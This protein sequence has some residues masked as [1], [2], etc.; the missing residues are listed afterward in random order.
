[1]KIVLA[2]SYLNFLITND[3]ILMPKYYKKGR[4]IHFKG[5]WGERGE[6]G[7]RGERGE[8]GGERGEGREGREKGKSSVI[9]I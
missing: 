5:L 9:F 1:M 4:S 8:R 6:R 3:I 7:K 2:T